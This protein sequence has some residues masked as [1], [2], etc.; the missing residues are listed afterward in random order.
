MIELTLV[1]LSCACRH[2]MWQKEAN[3]A[4]LASMLRKMVL[5]DNVASGILHC[6]GVCVAAEQK[7]GKLHLDVRVTCQ[8]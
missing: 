1:W 3:D 5:P 6:L 8:S 7:P 4:D 2:D